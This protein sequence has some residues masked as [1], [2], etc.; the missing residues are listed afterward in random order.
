M[1][2]GAFGCRVSSRPQTW[3]HRIAMNA[4]KLPALGSTSQQNSVWWYYKSLGS[5]G[6]L[7]MWLYSQVNLWSLWPG[8]GSQ[9]LWDGKLLFSW[10]GKQGCIRVPRGQWGSGSATAM[11]D[12]SWT[13]RHLYRQAPLGSS[14]A[15]WPRVMFAFLCYPSLRGDHSLKWLKTVP[16]KG[17]FRKVNRSPLS[18]AVILL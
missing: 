12:S 2:L 4:W 1:L 7:Q 14:R 16:E 15:W 5:S 17:I 13:H 8:P 9:P 10:L 11:G 6:P 18:E 3:V